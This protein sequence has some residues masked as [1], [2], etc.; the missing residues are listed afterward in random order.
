ML[1]KVMATLLVAFM[2]AGS[3]TTV[4]ASADTL[5]IEK[6]AIQ[7]I[8]NS[9][10]V[11]L[12]NGQVK[13]T[14][15]K[16]ADTKAQMSGARGRL[17]YANS[18]QL[19]EQIILLPLQLENSLTQVTNGQFITTNAVRLSAYQGYINL[20]KANY[21]QNVQQNLLN[22]I[23]ADYKKAQLQES[24][25][26]ISSWQLRLSEI[27]YLKVQYQYKNAQ[28]GSNSAS[29]ALNNMMGE[30]PSKQF[31]SLQDSNIIPAA[32]IKPLVDY[33][34]MAL[35]NR[36]DVINAQ[37]ALDIKKKQYE[38]GIAEIPNDFQFYIQKQEY[39]IESAQNDLDL[40]KISVQ[41]DIAKL[42][43]NL[44]SAMKNLEA[45]KYL[46]EQA[47]LNYQAAEVQYENAQISSLEFAD[48]K[49]AKAQADINY[50]NAQFDAWLIQTTMDSACGIGYQLVS[51]TAASNFPISQY[52]SKNKVNPK[53]KPD[54]D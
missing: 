32:Q 46:N 11:Q 34:N 23:E 13:L 25:G 44:E 36:A 37:G 31:S 3:A 26:E 18:Y 30:D 45:M 27:A 1:K 22:S 15:K 5:D 16:Y 4:K 41:E 7:A 54:R 40:A 42:Y 29:M 21:A 48:A 6:V 35:A 28:K 8:K 33:V 38:Y 47:V 39:A 49:V 14:Q 51:S 12:I 17:P 52:P 19:V 24:L 50:E 53:E 43:I 10:A 9:Q 2:L 20:L